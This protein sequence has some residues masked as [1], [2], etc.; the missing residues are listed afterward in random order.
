MIN[1]YEIIFY[2]SYIF[3][4]ASSLVTLI[5]YH[6][7]VN[8]L[9]ARKDFFAYSILCLVAAFW[10]AIIFIGLV[11]RTLYVKQNNE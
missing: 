1:P 7:K 5:E 10:P 9:Y 11:N 8:G 4:A 3:V 2:G 6:K